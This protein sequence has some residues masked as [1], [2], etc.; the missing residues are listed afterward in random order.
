MAITGIDHV[1]LAMPPGSEDT[2]RAFYRDIIGL[3]EAD[4]P[5]H[6]RVN[7]G[8]WFESGTAHIHLGVDEAFA[9]ARKAHPALLV[10]DLAALA[11][12]LREKG[13][14]FKPGKPLEGYARGDIT[15]PFG[16]R[17]ELMQRL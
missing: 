3:R 5:E 12:Q 7:G 10:E 16:N 11:A 17:I 1:Q 9:P 8:C 2:A 6:L 15:D 13:V 14:A 4:K